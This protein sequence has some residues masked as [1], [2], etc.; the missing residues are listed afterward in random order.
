MVI[1]PS[2]SL[3]DEVK[4]QAQVLVPVLNALRAELGEDR[5]NR[6]VLNALRE[7]SRDMYRRVGESMTGSPK[8]KWAVLTAEAAPRIGT[9]IDVQM[10]KVESE[11]MEFNVMGCRYAD[12]FRQLGEPELGAVLL[13]EVDN[14]VVE[15]A[16]PEVELTRTQTIMRGASYCDFRYRMKS[17]DGPKSGTVQHGVGPDALELGSSPRV[18]WCARRSSP[19]RC[20]TNLTWNIYGGTPGTMVCAAKRREEPVDERSTRTIVGSV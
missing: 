4:M 12:F 9:D 13:C 18:G 11:A 8:E 2:I 16:G 10:L 20:A 1:N 3:L 19:S 7:W 5:A 6:L 14:H 17:G 15:V